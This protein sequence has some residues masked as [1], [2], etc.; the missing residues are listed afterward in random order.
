MKGLTPYLVFDGSCREAMEFYQQTLGGELQTMRFDQGSFDSP[1]EAK[2]R[3][4]HAH[5]SRGAF[6]LMASDTMPGMPYSQGNNAWLNLACD[7]P[8]EL[9]TLYSALSSGGREGMA[10]HDSF[11]GDRFAMLTD[12]FG[13]HWML[14]APV[15]ATP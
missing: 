6:V 4:V 10:P 13:V 7:T 11:W 8:D 14:N 3:L 12:R 5:L 1:P 9:E 2:D 15:P